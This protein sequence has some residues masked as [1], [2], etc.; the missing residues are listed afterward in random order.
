MFHFTYVTTNTVNGKKYYGLHST[1]D[2]NDGY[3]GSG[4]LLKQAIKKYGIGAFK[5]DILEFFSTREEASAAEMELITEE[6]INSKMY[7][8]LN[9]GGDNCSGGHSQQTKDKISSALSGKNNPMYGVRTPIEERHKFA[10]FS[11]RTHTLEAKLKISKANKGKILSPEAKANI[12]KAQ[13]GVSRGLGKPK[14]ET[15]RKNISKAKTGANNYKFDPRPIKA[16]NDVEEL[17]FDNKKQAAQ[18]FNTGTSNISKACD[19]IYQTCLGYTW[20]YT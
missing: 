18:Y 14:S 15:H 9:P 19:K 17:F 12:S 10:G 2:L 6:V 1:F 11:G 3:V 7:Y 16:S 8:N 20:E 4:K 5:R 13:R